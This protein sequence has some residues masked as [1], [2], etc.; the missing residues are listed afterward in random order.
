MNFDIIR[1]I[2]TILV[3]AMSAGL[4]YFSTQNSEMEEAPPAAQLP[5][6]PPPR[7]YVPPADIRVPFEYDVFISTLPLKPEIEETAVA[8]STAS[9]GKKGKLP[10]KDMSCAYT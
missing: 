7:D 3:V 1:W 2:P 4:V 5:L 10:P 6:P 9:A 8:I